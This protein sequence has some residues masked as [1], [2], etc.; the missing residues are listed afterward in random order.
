MIS[1][2]SSDGRIAADDLVVLADPRQ[3]PAAL[4]RGDPDLAQARPDDARLLGALQP[5]IGAIPVEAMRAAN[6]SVDRDHDKATPARPPR[7]WKRSSG[8]SLGR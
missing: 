2:F 4:R 5:L 3:R 6:L 1:A 8:C 7:R